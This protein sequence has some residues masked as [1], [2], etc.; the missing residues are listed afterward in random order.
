MSFKEKVQKELDDFRAWTSQVNMQ[1]HLAKSELQAEARTAFMAAEQNAA[2]L[3]AKLGDLG[4]SVDFNVQLIV[5]Q[6]KENYEK[7]KGSIGKS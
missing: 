2:K 6:L 5:E 1:A 3:E 7:V 4:E